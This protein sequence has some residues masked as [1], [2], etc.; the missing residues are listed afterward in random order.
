MSNT[1]TAAITAMLLIMVVIMKPVMSRFSIRISLIFFI[2]D[3]PFQLFIFTYII[4][5]LCNNYISLCLYYQYEDTFSITVKI[6]K[7]RADEAVFFVQNNEKKMP[8]I[9]WRRKNNLI[10]LKS[11][12][13]TKRIGM[14]IAMS[15]D[16]FTLFEGMTTEHL[17]EIISE[18]KDDFL[19]IFDIHNNKIE[20]FK[21]VWTSLRYSTGFWTMLWTMSCLQYMR[22]IVRYLWGI[23]PMQPQEKKNFI[24]DKDIGTVFWIQWNNSISDNPGGKNYKIWF[25]CPLYLI[26]QKFVRRFH[27]SSIRKSVQ[28]IISLHFVDNNI[29][30]IRF[31]VYNSNY[32]F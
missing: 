18:S 11:Y 15:Q 25:L 21:S 2:L 31:C 6:Q 1:I 12:S 14:V 8:R 5:I 19:Y 3:Y 32:N 7:I 30:F 17:M 26:L 20:I 23:C 28:I 29:V 9:Y 4:S 16:I 13:A 27:R 10:W 24:N 22:R